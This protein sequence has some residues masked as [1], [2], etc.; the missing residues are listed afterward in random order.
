MAKQ[1]MPGKGVPFPI[2]DW[3]SV[4]VQGLTI[5]NRNNWFPAMTL[6]IGNP[7]E[8]DEDTKATLDLIYEVERR[9]LFAFFIPSIFTPLHDTRMADAKGRDR[10]AAA[11][12]A[13]VAAHDEVLEDEPAA[14]AGEL[15]GADGVAP[16]L[17]RAVALEAAQAERPELH[18]AAADVRQR[19]AGDA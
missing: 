7:G 14:R 8:T 19:A 11:D 13:A 4:V 10:D 2:E 16:G 5:L 15:V 18:L 12:A 1:I 9:G 3:P 17:D 6:M